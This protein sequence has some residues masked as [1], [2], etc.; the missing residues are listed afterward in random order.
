MENTDQDTLRFNKTTQKNE[1][2]INKRSSK[3]TA[4]P[5]LDTKIMVSRN[6]CRESDNEK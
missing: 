2:I 6:S 1:V 3:R 4:T 5:K